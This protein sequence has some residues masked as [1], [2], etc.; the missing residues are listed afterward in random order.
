MMKLTA[1]RSRSKFWWIPSILLLLCFKL[2]AQTSSSY[3]IKSTSFS[4]GSG[5]TQSASYKL[6]GTLGQSFTGS[7]SSASYNLKSGFESNLINQSFD[8]TMVNL[9]LNPTS[10]VRGSDVTAFFTVRNIGTA[11]VESNVTVTGYLSLNPTFENTDR[12]ILPTQNVATALGAGVDLPLTAGI[13]ITIPSDV[14]AGSYYIV[15]VVASDGVKVESNQNNNTISSSLSVITGDDTTPPTITPLASGV[16]SAGSNVSETVTDNKAVSWVRFIHRPIVGTNFDSV[17]VTGT[18]SSFV[19]SLQEAWADQLGMEGYFRASDA[20]GN[21]AKSDK[22]YWYRQADPKTVI[23]FVSNF[24]GSMDTYTMFSIPFDLESKGIT[25]VFDELSEGRYDKSVWRLF[26]YQSDSYKENET[27]TIQPGSGYWVNM[28]TKTDVAVGAGSVVKKNQSDMFTMTLEKG[29]N[30]IGNPYPFNIDWPTIKSANPN[31]GLN[32]LW[33]FESGQYVSKDVL[34]TWKGAFVFSDN[35]GNVVFPVTSKTNAG[36]RISKNEMD[37]TLDAD[38]WI[39][40]MTIN[41]NDLTQTSAIGMH[42]DASTSKDRFDEMTIPRFIEYLEMKSTHKEFFSPY[43]ST[44]VVPTSNKYEWTFELK[45]SQGEGSVSISWDQ[46]A[47]SKDQSAIVL[48]DL[49]DQ[50]WL[51]MKTSSGYNFSW[52]EGR[53]LKIVYSRDGVVDPGFTFLGQCYPN[54][55]TSSVSIPV[56][57]NPENLNTQINIY[58]LLGNR[59]KTL[60]TIFSNPGMQI[61]NWDGKDDSGNDVAAGLLVYK[62]MNTSSAPAKRMI[63][64]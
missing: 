9:T 13:K 49:L 18:G 30:Q 44:D 54:P 31:A 19:V 53:Q 42:P 2:H 26:H 39:L 55:F 64:R 52:K 40:P 37:A 62:L 59:I 41:F 17:T 35:G 6:H 14:A 16:F 25:S 28:K 57:V 20:A 23:P 56:L 60:T 48:I 33:L 5:S 45:S 43:F 58:D 12:G 15:L 34:A 8:L 21:I 50:T 24:G 47:F 22:I 3:L 38:R 27:M 1:Q 51:N 32:S 7:N 4:S 63:K 61:V 36:G 11:A 46:S 29:W 10:V